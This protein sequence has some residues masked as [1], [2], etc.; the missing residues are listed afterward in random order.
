MFQDLRFGLRMLGKN[1]GFTAM[2]VLSLA[3]G[4][5]ANAAIFSL[6]D[7]LLLKQLPVRQPAQ[8]VF[9]ETGRPQFKR[10]SQISYATYEQLRKQTDILS[11]ASFFSYT[12]RLNASLNGQP[13]IVEGQPV[14]GNF[15]SVL[16]VDAATGRTL[17]DEDDRGNGEQAVV[18]ISY[19]YWQRRFGLSSAA[20][21]QTV[22]LNNAP[23]TIIGV[24]PAEFSGVIVGNAPDVFVPSTAAERILPHRFSFRDDWLPFVLGR[25]K[26]GVSE[27]QATSALTLTLQQAALAEGGSELTEE[28][29][30]AIQR[31]P[32]RLPSASQ[33]FSVLQQQFSKPLRLLMAF[34]ALVLLIACANVANLMLARGGA[35]RKEIALRL[36]LG[37]GRLRLIRQ[38]LTESLLLAFLGGGLGLLIASWGSGLLWTVVSSGRNP[39]TAGAKFSLNASFDTRIFG[40]SVVVSLLA[41]VL[42]GLAPAWRATRLELSSTLKDNNRDPGRGRFRLGRLLVVAQVAISVALL[43]GAGLFVRSL[44]RLKSADVG[45]QR[46][47][48][49]LFSV[50]PQL[51]GYKQAQIGPL[52]QQMLERLGAAPGVRSISLARQGLLSGRGTQGSIKV[53]GRTPPVGENRFIEKG[54]DS[55]WNAPYLSQV[56][57][58]FFATLGMPI[59]RGREFG[60]QDNATAPRVAVVNEGFAR[61]YFGSEDVIGQ[62]FDRGEDD[63]GI[64]E[65]VGLVK[66]AKVADIREQ[67]PRA[68]YVPFLQDPGSWRET[69]FQVHTTGDPFALVG[70]LRKEMQA[71][72][73]NLPLFRVRTLEAQVDES[74][75]RDRLLTTLTSLFG[76]LALLLACAGLY[77][78][79]SF[80]VTQRTHEIGIRM[81]LG[82]DRRAVLQMILR[83]GMALILVGLA[84]GLVGAYLFT[85]YLESLST[86]LY[87]VRPNDP[88]T[89]AAMSGLLVLVAALACFLP[90]RRA[91][92]VDPLV[93]LREE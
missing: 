13:E 57:P 70:A 12:T 45:F 37:A 56:G 26:A 28:K 25:L 20:L 67:T 32:I 59:L 91:T 84:V 51:I 93:A 66:D 23:F 75:G 7:A 24:T 10:S 38:L 80:S 79:L 53:P 21:G 52:Y 55:E 27:A 40:F 62:R 3:L 77:G 88:L 35:R 39:V 58:G 41:A 89:Y 82:A 49:L 90:A 33:G 86:M 43:I 15:F 85:R 81:A 19:S 46:E 83:Q 71:I 4:I 60:S 5:G 63:G 69:T 17:T 68:F 18:V 61:Y 11:D 92:R 87:G 1:P 14:S 64:V 9:L 78:V 72:D 76:G 22:N 65:I 16:G 47:G 30:Q 31:Q 42:F 74:L 36:A 8:L 50:D 54:D 48:V 44:N 73:P 29:R 6:V 2:A 34:V